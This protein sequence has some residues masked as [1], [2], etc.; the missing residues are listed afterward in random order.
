MTLPSTPPISL[1]QVAAELGVALPLGLDETNVR[2]LA[3]KPTGPVSLLD[4]LGKSAAGPV[5][6]FGGVWEKNAIA[7]SPN[8]TTKYTCD[9]YVKTNGTCSTTG[10]GDADPQWYSPTT[11][12]IGSSYWVRFT[13]QSGSGTFRSSGLGIWLQVNTNRFLTVET[14][15]SFY[16]GADA[17]VLVEFAASNGGAVIMSDTVSIS[18]FKD[19]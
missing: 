7:S 19:F 13:K 2:N 9:Y 18:V 4:L 6:Q 14:M 10:V 5:N 15:S 12:N 17:V 3:G 11:T 8:D 1:A 16:T